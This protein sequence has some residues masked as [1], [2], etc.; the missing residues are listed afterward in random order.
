MHVQYYAGIFKTHLAEQYRLLK[1]IV[2]YMQILIKLIITLC[3]SV[4]L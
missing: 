2:E 1:A 3:M 4:C